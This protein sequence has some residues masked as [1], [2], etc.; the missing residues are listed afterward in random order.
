MLVIIEFLGIGIIADKVNAFFFGD[1]SSKQKSSSEPTLRKFSVPKI[2]KSENKNQKEEEKTEIQKNVDI[3]EP[4]ALTI[5]EN[6]VL[7]QQ[8]EEVVSLINEIKEFKNVSLEDNDKTQIAEDE[9]EVVESEFVE[10]KSEPENQSSLI[11][12]EEYAA[13]TIANEEILE[14][15][16]SV[17]FTRQFL[18]GQVRS[19]V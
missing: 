19:L 16:T 18:V 8:P 11:T 14:D 15:G 1:K 3:Y 5:N 7:E 4:E 12:Q 13:L 6:A 2:L 10:E 9:P 17:R